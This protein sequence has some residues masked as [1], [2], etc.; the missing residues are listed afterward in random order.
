[1]SGNIGFVMAFSTVLCIPSMMISYA[2]TYHNLLTD[3]F[4]AKFEWTKQESVSKNSMIGG[5]LVLGL[6]FGALIG[7]PMMKIGRRKSLMISIV[8]GIIGNIVS[9]FIG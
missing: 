2:L 5:S 6:T 9:C 4:N 3:C 1:M 7:G 8:I